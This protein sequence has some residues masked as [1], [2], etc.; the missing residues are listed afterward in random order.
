[1]NLRPFMILTTAFFFIFEPAF[2]DDFYIIIGTY[3]VQKEAQQA[4][5]TK[6]GWVLNTNFY[7]QLTPN[8]FAVVRGPFT[9]KKLAE[10]NLAMLMESDK[11]RGSYVKNAGTINIQV[12]IGNK[13]ISPQMLAAIFG[14]LRIDITEHK[15]GSNPC[16][17]QEPYKGLTFSYVTLAREYDEKQGKLSFNPQDNP[18]DVGAF[19][20]IKSTGEIDRMRICAE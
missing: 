13:A 15:G 9:A 20:E 7:D 4:A 5:A 14:E 16:E 10:Q 11:Y 12:K 19:W 8:L 17:P 2:A 1:M 6:D 3:K 18:I